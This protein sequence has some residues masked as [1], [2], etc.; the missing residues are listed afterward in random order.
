[1]VLYAFYLCLAPWMAVGMLFGL[2]IIEGLFD[3]SESTS[4]S[5]ESPEGCRE[6]RILIEGGAEN[7]GDQ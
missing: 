6:T 7:N 3:N 2:V 4:E 5:N 1:M